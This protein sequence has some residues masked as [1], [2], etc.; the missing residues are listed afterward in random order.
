MYYKIPTT[1]NSIQFSI[2]CIFFHEG[3]NKELSKSIK[4]SLQVILMN[5]KVKYCLETHKNNHS[6]ICYSE[7][8]MIRI[9]NCSLTDTY[10]LTICKCIWRSTMIFHEIV[11]VIFIR[12]F[13]WSHEY[14]L[15]NREVNTVQSFTNQKINQSNQL[16][17]YT[18]YVPESELIQAVLEDQKSFLLLYTEQRLTVNSKLYK[19]NT[20]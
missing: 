13:L 5:V 6:H 9:K 8:Q 10:F 16:N 19:L 1:I 7:Y 2:Y 4:A 20:M 11:K 18:H 17:S 15:N 12:I 3:F 14:H